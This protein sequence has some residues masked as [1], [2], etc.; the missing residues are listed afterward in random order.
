MQAKKKQPDE[1]IEEQM[2]K[3]TNATSGSGLLR[4]KRIAHSQGS[5]K[6]K[7]IKLKK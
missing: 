1:S 2:D 3:D 7:S 6:H 4:K 5:K